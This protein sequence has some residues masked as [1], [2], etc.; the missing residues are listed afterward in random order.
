LSKAPNAPASWDSQGC[1]VCRRQWEAA[2]RPILIA[3]NVADHSELYR[4][5]VCGALWLM[6]ERAAFVV[7]PEEIQSTYPGVSESAGRHP[8]RSEAPAGDGGVQY[9]RHSVAST[10]HYFGLVNGRD[11]IL[12]GDEWVPY[13]VYKSGPSW[14]RLTGEPGADVIAAD[15]LPPD[16]PR[17]VQG[18]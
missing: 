14:W 9:W 4:C 16:A 8:S 15:D 12:R 17:W 3:E 1:A 11:F 13:D 7:Q 5:A 18:L 10:D 6:T 2:E